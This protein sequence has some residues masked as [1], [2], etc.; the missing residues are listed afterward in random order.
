[1]RQRVLAVSI[2]GCFWGRA[3]PEVPDGESGYARVR[4]VI[5]D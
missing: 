3:V 2:R 4:K 1:M 5:R